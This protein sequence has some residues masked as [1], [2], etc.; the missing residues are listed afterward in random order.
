M[1]RVLQR[2]RVTFNAHT[3]EGRGYIGNMR[4]FEATGVGT[5]LLTD[6][7]AN[8]SDLFVEDQEV[9]TYRS[10]EECI[11]KQRYLLAHD[12]IRRQIALAGQKRTLKD[13]TVMNRCLQID[14]I[15]QKRI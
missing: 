13:H 9:V 6:T 12:D 1:L 11:E 4:L 15:I 3:D 14:E 8:L 7:G 2:S 5:C 10:L